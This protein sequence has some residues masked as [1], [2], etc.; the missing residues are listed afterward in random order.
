MSVHDRPSWGAAALAAAV[1][2]PKWVTRHRGDRHALLKRH[3]R[4]EAKRLKQGRDGLEALAPLLLH[5]VSDDRTLRVA[6][7]YLE[8]YGGQ[9]P[10]P[11]GL[12][13]ED[14][15]DP[16]VWEWCRATRDAIR[17]GEYEVGD[18]EVVRISKGPHRGT[19]PLVLQSIFDRVVQSGPSSRWCSRSSTR[20]S[21]SARSATGRSAATCKRW[22]WP[23][24]SSST[25]S[26]GS[27]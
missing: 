10:G 11:D 9:A 23:S 1:L 8:E 6:W 16:F 12:R 27:G 26:A 21:T 18:E 25:R 24:G 22:Q 17:R 3:R 15:P 2:N 7:D 14:L 13:Y 19:R 20:S 4:Q 5:R